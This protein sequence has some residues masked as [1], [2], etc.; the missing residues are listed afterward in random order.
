MNGWLLTPVSLYYSTNSLTAQPLFPSAHLLLGLLGQPS[1]GNH[2]STAK[3]NAPS[4]D[5]RCFVV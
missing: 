3:E 1:S 4:H 2:G 5:S